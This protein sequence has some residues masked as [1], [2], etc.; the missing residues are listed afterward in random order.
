MRDKIHTLG[1]DDYGDGNLGLR[2]M[3]LFFLSHQCNPI[4]NYLKLP[5]FDLH[6]SE[7]QNILQEESVELSKKS[8]LI[9]TVA[10]VDA[11]L[12]FSVDFFLR[13]TFSRRKCPTKTIGAF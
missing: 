4:C 2:G 11:F 5:K 10:F 9:G 13:K 12:K 6:I 8:V 7:K 3:T 1:G